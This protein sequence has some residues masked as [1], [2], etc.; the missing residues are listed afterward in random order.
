MPETP[1]FVPPFAPYIRQ[2]SLPEVGQCGQERLQNAH[3]LVVGL[4]G[5]GVPAVTYLASAGVGK[6]SLVDDDSVHESNLNRQFFYTPQ[7]VGKHKALCMAEKMAQHFP[8]IQCHTYMEKVTTASLPALFSKVGKV[9]VILLCVDCI[10]TRLCV[11]AY[12][13]QHGI[14]LVDGGVDGFYGYMLTVQPQERAGACLA[15]MHT[16]IP[17]SRQDPI[18]ALGFICG[19]IGSLQAGVACMCILGNENPY[20]NTL[21]QYDGK[22]GEWEKIPWG[23]HPSCSLHE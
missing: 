9:D 18:P 6:L 2:M 4:G 19:V 3:V 16:H 13:M 7:D 21:L 20:K 1:P 22:S 15:C 17:K 8:H 23:R 10:A 11:N 5:L 14:F 12:A